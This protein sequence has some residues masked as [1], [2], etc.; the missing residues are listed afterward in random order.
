M[1]LKVDLLPTVKKIRVGEAMKLQFKLTD[2]LTD[3]P[4]DGLDIRTLTSLVPGVWQKR[5]CAEC[6]G[7]GLYEVALSVPRKGIYYVFIESPSEEVKYIQL[8]HFV[9]EAA[10]Q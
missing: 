7:D 4:Q 9:L 6:L 3:R 8:P 10:G 1:R 2:S 5:N